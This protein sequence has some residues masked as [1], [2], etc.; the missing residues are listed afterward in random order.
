MLGLDSPVLGTTGY[1]HLAAFGDDMRKAVLAFILAFGFGAMPV[2]AQ[3]PMFE[4]YTML[5]PGDTFNSRGAPL[6]DVCAII[7]QDR[8]NVHRFGNP[9]GDPPD[10]F[11]TTADRRAMIAG[12]CDYVRSYHTV[13]RIRSQFIGFVR[14]VVYGSGGV[15]T[16]LQIFEAA[17]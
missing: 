7:Q 3:S 12:R 8:A 13:D 5:T 10:P 15:V 6:N 1:P 9:D 4:Y 11:F 17:G 2:G 16:R 14:V